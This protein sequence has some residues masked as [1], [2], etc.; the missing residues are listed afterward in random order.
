MFRGAN[1]EVI[2]RGYKKICDKK[3]GIR[4]DKD[5]MFKEIK[6]SCSDVIRGD[7]DIMCREDKRRC[8]D[9]NIFFIKS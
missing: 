4:G 8:H 2:F 5:I 3:D 1:E 7:K 9:V 6:L